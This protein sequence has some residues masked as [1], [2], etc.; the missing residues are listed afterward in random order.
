MRALSDSLEQQLRTEKQH[1]EEALQ[2]TQQHFLTLQ[3]QLEEAQKRT[4]EQ[5]EA[6]NVDMQRELQDKFTQMKQ[7]REALHTQMTEELAKLNIK[8]P[9]VKQKVKTSHSLFSDSDDDDTPGINAETYDLKQK[10]MSLKVDK[11]ELLEEAK[12]M[13]QKTGETNEEWKQRQDDIRQQVLNVERQIKDVN[14]ELQQLPPMPKAGVYPLV[15]SGR[16]DGGGRPQL[17]YQPLSCAELALLKGKLPPMV[18]GGRRWYEKLMNQTLGLTLAVGDVMALVAETCPPHTAALVLRNSGLHGRGKNEQFDIHA[19]EFL[20]TI[21]DMFPSPSP[22]A[23]TF[24]P[25]KAG[26]DPITFLDTCVSKY[27]DAMGEHPHRTD[28][29]SCLFLQAVLEA[30][31]KQLKDTLLGTPGLTADRTLFTT[32][33]RH[34]ADLYNKKEKDREEKDRENQLELMRLNLSTARQNATKDKKE[35]KGK[36]Q[37][38]AT[39]PTTDSQTP[40]QT[41]ASVLYAS[42]PP[43]LGPIRQTH[44][45]YHDNTGPGGFRGSS[46]GRMGRPGGMG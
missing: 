7:D 24:D 34:H 20:R 15:A 5:M 42:Q 2:Y 10:L 27:L 30:L 11:H 29:T 23:P 1:K 40:P 18:D 16:T 28:T 12:Y 44:I 4:Q 13:R 26:T 38:M 36:T 46:R 33:F 43:P 32:H 8:Q 3:R 45:H 6:A 37:L 9:V 17:L 39:T 21:I 41:Q 22:K 19:E 14:E 25:F 35:I 31:P